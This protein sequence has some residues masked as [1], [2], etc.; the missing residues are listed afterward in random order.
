MKVS[1]DWLS[2][3]V[4]INVDHKK[5]AD[6]M[7]MSGTKVETIECKGEGLAN[8]FIGQIKEISP[9]PDA[10]KLII[11]QIDVG[12]EELVQ[13]VTGAS[14]VSVGDIIPVALHGAV[15]PNGLKIK[16]GKLRGIDSN[17]MLCSGDELGIENKYVN[18]KSKDGI[19]ILENEFEIGADAVEALGLKDTVIEFEITANR[20]DCRAMLGIA[21]ET[22]ATLGN[23]LRLPSGQVT[24]PVEG[25]VSIQLEVADKELCPRFVI[26]EVRDIEIKSSPQWMQQRLISYGIR[27]INNIVDI[28][29]Y[30][31][32]EYAQPL[33]AYDID[34]LKTG[35]IL[36]RRA[37]AGEKI[38][39]LDDQEFDLDEEVLLITDGEKAI[40]MAGVMGGANS[41]ITKD[42]KHVLLEA[43]MFDADNVRLTSRR[44]GIR[45][46][47]SSYFEKGVDIERQG[48]A[49]DRAC[50]LIEVLGA[51]KVVDHIVD[52]YE[53]QFERR[54][55]ESDFSFIRK[56][57]GQDISDQE[58]TE[59]L[60][61][62]DFQ[63][64]VN[65]DHIKVRVPA[66]RLDMTIKEDLV[67]EVARLY[68]Y[69]KI[70]SKPIIA[71]V[72]QAL[73][74]SER[75]FE[76]I[77]KTLSQENGLM[78]I[79]TYSFISPKSIEK[80]NLQEEK[81]LKL[82]SLLNP[83]GEETSVMRTSL[84][85]GML[86][87]LATNLSYKNESFAA[88]ELG[89]TFFKNEE[90]ALPSEEKYLV[91]GIY[92]P[93]EDFFTAKGRLEGILRAIGIKD[94]KYESQTENLSYHPGRCADVFVK[95]TKIGTIGEVHPRVLERFGI[96]R[97]V[98]L[99]EIEV[100]LAQ[101]VADLE[102]HYKPV[103]RYPAVSKDIA[104]VVDRGVKV[105]QLEEIIKKYGKKNLESVKLFDI[106]QSEQL[107]EDKKS[108]AY[109]LTFR[110]SDRTLTDE[111]T[112]KILDKILLQLEIEANAKLR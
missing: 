7:T 46:E 13:I 74:S 25:Q 72:T 47:A 31:M 82:L 5:Y 56:I 98:Y 22:A 51:G 3:Y 19:L 77:L 94:A 2:E 97:R 9:H 90:G 84:I 87:V 76:D 30:V 57:I 99:F 49:I 110:A 39:T 24:N 86:E 40:G 112:N 105:G 37:Q 93:K 63:L 71:P 6:M 65:G 18:E 1:L 53:G 95:K 32:V 17:G 101:R 45:T 59:I 108:V 11:T 41:Q 88:Y 55:I 92:G 68:G 48:L 109:A 62:L 61:S 27:P 69:N 8:L 52:S 23:N 107:G 4:D 80:A 83:L 81:H 89:N 10:D 28:T 58:I 103:P 44:L 35:K 85:P 73:K 26:R 64:E 91:A 36:V 60:E 106:F 16:N 111:E 33:H 42:T 38:T 79:Q 50:H 29:N 96:K 21:K 20:P 43:A 100:K 75:Q 67:E 15:L 12:R 66:E 34:Q 54:I 104:L 102:L 78:E 70:Q 14:N